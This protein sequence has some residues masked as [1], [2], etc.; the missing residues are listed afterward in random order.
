[1]IFAILSG[2][3]FQT[4]NQTVQFRLECKFTRLKYLNSVSD[5]DKIFLALSKQK[6]KVNIEIVITKGQS[7]AA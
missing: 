2:N 1:M 6:G 7:H 5:Q 3:E 4:F